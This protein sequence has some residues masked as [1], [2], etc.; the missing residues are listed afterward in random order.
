MDS[1]FMFITMLP[2]RNEEKSLALVLRSILVQSIDP[3][4]ICDDGST[5]NSLEILRSFKAEFPERIFLIV[6][7]DRGFRLV[8]EGV[9]N[10]HNSLKDY[11]SQFTK[12]K[13]YCMPG[14]DTILPL[15]YY[16]TIRKAF[17]DDPDLGIV[18]GKIQGEKSKEVR[19]ACRVYSR[20]LFGKIYPYTPMIGWDDI[21]LWIARNLGYKMKIIP[22]LEIIQTRKTGS[23]LNFWKRWRNRGWSM[24]ALGYWR[25]FVLAKILRRSFPNFLR[26][27]PM[28][29]GWKTYSGRFASY[30]VQHMIVKNQK[31]RLRRK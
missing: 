17:Y 25:P 28:V 19:S 10:A 23:S 12:A 3:I 11:V 21:P 14:A 30:S 31:K 22:E 1:D 18:C 15:N 8:G 13:F 26:M 16:S 24:K 20:E 5:D 6:K 7:P 27:I 2:V 29:Y 4:L 9:A